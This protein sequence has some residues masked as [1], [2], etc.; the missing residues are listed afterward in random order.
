[1]VAPLEG[2]TVARR[3]GSRRQGR[4]R[5]GE[6]DETCAGKRGKGRKGREREGEGRG[7]ELTLGIQ[8]PVITVTGS[9]RARGGREVGEREREMRLLRGKNQIREIEKRGA[10]TWG[11]RWGARG[12]RARAGPSRAGP[13]RVGLGCIAGQKPT[14]CTTTES[15]SETKSETRRDGRAIKHNHQTKEICFGMMQHPCQLRFFFYTPYGHQSLYYFET[16]KKERNGKR[17][18]SNT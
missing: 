8:N 13:G 14:T 5:R 7:R 15:N 2:R 18:E 6:E 11:R 10:H 4:A 9:P 12:V 3:G 1:M 17:K 16:G